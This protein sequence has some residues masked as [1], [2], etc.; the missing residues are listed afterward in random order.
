M[1]YLI[2]DRH[3]EIGVRLALGARA[4]DITALILRGSLIMAALGVIVGEVLALSMSR[5]VQP[6][7]FDTSAK[8][9]SVFV[10]VGLLLLSVALIAT[11]VPAFRARRVNPLEAL[12]SE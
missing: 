10:T 6:L 5:W 7:L 2:A 9:V 3:H 11:L 1:S 4:A 8:D 12:R